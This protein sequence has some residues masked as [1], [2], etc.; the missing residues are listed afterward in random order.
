MTFDHQYTYKYIIYLDRYLYNIHIS[1]DMEEEGY[2]SKLI[3]I[4]RLNHDL[5]NALPCSEKLI[6]YSQHTIST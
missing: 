2:N 1:S 3:F 4:G 5:P 6:V